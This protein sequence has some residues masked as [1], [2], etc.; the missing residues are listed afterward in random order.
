MK[1][2]NYVVNYVKANFNWNKIESKYASKSP[3]DLLKDKFGN[4]AD[5][6]LL[7]VGL[8]NAAGI[9]AYPLILSTRDNGRIKNNYPLMKAFNYVI[10]SANPEGQNILS[11]ATEVFCPN[12]MIPSRCINE[13]GLLIKE[14][15][16]QWVPL[17]QSLPSEIEKV[18]S[19]D[20]IERQPV[21]KV[22]VTASKYDAIRYRNEY[23]NNK[24][25]IVENEGR[26]KYKIEKS[27]VVTVN[28]F[29]REVPFKFEYRAGFNAEAIENKIYVSP[30]LEEVLTDNPL[31]LNNRTYPIDFAYPVTRTFVST[32][33]I[34][35][36]YKI[37]F[38]PKEEKI[39]NEMFEL[40]YK[41]LKSDKDLQLTFNYTFKKSVYPATEYQNLKYYFNEIIKKGNEKIVFVKAG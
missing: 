13:K 10:I 14:G 29:A 11:D 36:G 41:V 3:S 37:D 4:S 25:K 28:A 2:F 20:S 35:Q 38:L 24:N 39:L 17:Q 30:F 6:N 27:S 18:I 23:G 12:D 1:K 33:A 26:N 9:E 15:P 40:N 22:S 16:V 19:M 31:K 34:P 21:A 5:L 32:I 7:A 8:L